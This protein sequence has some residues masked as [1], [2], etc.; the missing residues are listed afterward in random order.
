MGRTEVNGVILMAFAW[1]RISAQRV[2][3]WRE[4]VPRDNADRPYPVF[5]VGP[6]P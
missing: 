4:A 3:G 2:H 6:R 5:G 1:V